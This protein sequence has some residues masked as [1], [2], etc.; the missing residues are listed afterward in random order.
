MG[1]KNVYIHFYSEEDNYYASTSK[2]FYN[3]TPRANI[4]PRR[5]RGTLRITFLVTIVIKIK[6]SYILCKERVAS[7]FGRVSSV[8]RVRETLLSRVRSDI[9]WHREIDSRT[10]S[11]LLVRIIMEST[12]GIAVVSPVFSHRRWNSCSSGH[13]LHHVCITAQSAETYRAKAAPYP[14]LPENGETLLSPL[15]VCNFLRKRCSA[16]I[17]HCYGEYW[18][19]YRRRGPSGWKQME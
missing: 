7:P 2:L 6:L 10:R 5:M 1:E 14:R 17:H 16:V 8:M 3:I 18:D 12:K 19:I 9:I 4:I 11:L 15:E 13:D